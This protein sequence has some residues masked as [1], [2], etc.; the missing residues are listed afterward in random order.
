[1]NNVQLTYETPEARSPFSLVDV[2]K[3]E[4]NDVDAQHD[5]KA[6]AFA[7]WNV[8]DFTVRQSPNLPDGKKDH[9]DSGSY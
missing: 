5:P 4:F 2:K 7:L 9:V 8:D 6:P 3:A 1:M